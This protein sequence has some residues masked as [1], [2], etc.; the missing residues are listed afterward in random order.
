MDRQTSTSETAFHD[1]TPIKQ[2]NMHYKINT[3]LKKNLF[4]KIKYVLHYVNETMLK[5]NIYNFYI[6]GININRDLINFLVNW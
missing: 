6:V 4:R 3:V 2:L 1:G 5:L